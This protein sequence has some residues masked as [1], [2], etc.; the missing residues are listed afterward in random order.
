MIGKADLVVMA[1]ELLRDP[2]F[3]L[4]AAS[5]LGVEVDYPLQYE[6]AKF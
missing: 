4:R 5:I 2:N 1:R 6:R 3:P